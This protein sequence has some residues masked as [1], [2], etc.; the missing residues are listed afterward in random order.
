MSNIWQK[1][2]LQSNSCSLK[3]KH[4]KIVIICRSIKIEVVIWKPTIHDGNVFQSSEV[5]GVFLPRINRLI[6]AKILQRISPETLVDWNICH[7]KW[8]V[9]SYQIWFHLF[10]KNTKLWGWLI[11]IDQKLFLRWHLSYLIDLSPIKY[12]IITKLLVVDNILVDDK[13][14]LLVNI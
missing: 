6:W 9:F 12:L 14:S 13:L 8:L 4:P 10:L 11:F 5:H 2:I 7:H 1:C 3:I